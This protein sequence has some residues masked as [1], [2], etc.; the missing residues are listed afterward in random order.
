MKNAL[1][2]LGQHAIQEGGDP[3]ACAYAVRG[4][5]SIRGA[6]GHVILDCPLDGFGMVRQAFLFAGRHFPR[7]LLQ[8]A[9]VPPMHRVDARNRAAIFLGLHILSFF[10]NAMAG[11]LTPTAVPQR[12][13]APFTCDICYLCFRHYFTVC[14]MEK[15]VHRIGLCSR[16]DAI[17]PLTGAWDS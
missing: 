6:G 10:V 17:P 7:K 1:R 9:T 13:K 12:I 15:Q 4:E 2:L 5:R 14:R 11:S 3:A 8:R 16:Y